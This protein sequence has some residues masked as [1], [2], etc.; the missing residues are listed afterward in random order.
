MNCWRNLLSRILHP[1]PSWGISFVGW[2]CVFAVA[3]ASV[4]AVPTM[5][6]AKLAAISIPN[7]QILSTT[8]H[9]A[10]GDLPAYCNLVGVINKRISTQDPDHFTYGIVFELNLPDTW[11]GN[12]ELTRGGVGA[13]LGRRKRRWWPR[14]CSRGLS[15]LHASSGS[16]LER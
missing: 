12:F 9:A 16:E 14:E 3:R 1:G 11:S 10:S 6:C 15:A 13:R 7:V 8:D 5:P 2:L 4:A